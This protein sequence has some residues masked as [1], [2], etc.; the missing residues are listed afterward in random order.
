MAGPTEPR[1]RPPRDADDGAGE[2][3]DPELRVL[4]TLRTL[5]QEVGQATDVREALEILVRRI[6]DAMR[7]DVCSVYLR[8]GGD[9]EL[10]LQA[11]LGLNEESVGRLRLPL[12]EGL[13]GLVASTREPVNVSDAAHHPA[14]RYFPESGEASF[15]AFLGVPLL[16]QRQL[17]GVLVVQNEE[18]RRFFDHEIDFLV[19]VSAQLAEVVSRV[20]ATSSLRAS[21]AAT[22]GA[23]T[24]LK[25]IAGA[26]GVAIGV[27]VADRPIP[28]NDVAR[29]E[30]ADPE[31]ELAALDEALDRFD[32][33]LES[34]ALGARE[35]LRAT[36]V[37]LFDAYRLILHDDTFVDAIRAE[38]RA[39]RTADGGLRVA[40]ERLA[41]V[42]DRMDDPY[43]R[44]RASDVRAIGNRLAFH[45]AT[46]HPRSR[47]YPHGT[48]LAGEEVALPRILDVPADR[49]AAIVCSGGSLLSHTVVVARA[50]EIPVVMGLGA[51][52][53]E[54]VDG[55]G[56]VVDG[57]TGRVWIDPPEAIRAQ[58]AAIAAEEREIDEA[59]Q[60]SSTLPCRTTDGVDVSIRANVGIDLDIDRALQARLDGVGLYRSE[61]LFMLRDSFPSEEEQYTDYRRV[62]EAFAPR[63]VTIRSLDI[64]GDK[65]L[66]YFP[67][68]E[69]NP[70]L[71]WRGIRVTLDHPELFLT[72]LRALLRADEGLGNLQLLLPMVSRV[73]EVEETRGLLTQAHQE[74]TRDGH[75]AKVPPLGVLIEVPAVLHDLEAFAEVVDFFSIGTNDLTQH[76]L[77]VDRSN[78]RVADLYDTLHPAVL[79]A[80]AALIERA[81]G[82]QT[83]VGVCGQIAGDPLGALVLLGLGVDWLSM[84]P[85]AA[86]RVKHLIRSMRS[87]QARETGRRATAMR[88]ATEVHALLEE[89][90]RDAGLGHLSRPS[91]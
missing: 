27:V 21:S 29:P 64:G 76:L 53:P 71:G 5:V 40:V 72:Q 39:G 37:P 31:A 56:V 91:R 55:R 66:S 80:L 89:A 67:I 86:A 65:P 16:H 30:E 20:E 26:P 82:A 19:T 70:F 3:V 81:H 69:Q 6:H 23:G 87:D 17:R 11:T 90:L 4:R 47:E 41:S 44:A 61:L 24:H 18:N 60:I 15:Q 13:V 77:A 34:G 73:E 54:T 59:V 50:L 51:M 78:A 22:A 36:L 62:L 35:G 33:E 58:Y 84:A 75:D 9:G 63:P 88:S 28:A 43:Q 2:R 10:V 38:I 8:D 52:Q 45:L 1:R 12:G 68:S 79:R 85:A 74:L 83:P 49:L 42:F 46:R 57:F 25:G 48:V 14:Y 7:V 32:D